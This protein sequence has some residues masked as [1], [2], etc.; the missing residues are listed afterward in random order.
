MDFAVRCPIQFW[1]V[2]VLIRQ[3]GTLSSTAFIL[4]Q[5]DIK[6]LPGFEEEVFAVS[7]AQTTL[8]N[9]ESGYSFCKAWII[10]R[11]SR[12]A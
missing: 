12:T 11:P 7:L 10:S 9:L 6:D 5:E 3:D 2:C 4:G 8:M 1:K